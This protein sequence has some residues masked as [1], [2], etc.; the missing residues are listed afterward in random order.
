[1]KSTDLST[2]FGAMQP[3]IIIAS[4]HNAITLYNR[5]AGTR[6]VCSPAHRWRQCWHHCPQI[7]VARLLL[8]LTSY[9]EFRHKL[10]ERAT[11]KSLIQLLEPTLD[12]QLLCLL[13]QTVAIL[14][15]DPSLHTLFGEIQV[16][17][18]L[19]QMLLPADD[20]YYTNHSTKFG[21]FV[22]HHAARI[23]VYLGM[24]DR[25]GSRVNL[26]HAIDALNVEKR[27][28][29][30][31]NASKDCP[32]NNE[33]DFIIDTCKTVYSA[34]E[35]SKTALSVEGVLQK[36]LAEL[37]KQAPYPHT[38]EPITEESP[39]TSSPPALAVEP[40]PSPVVPAIVEEA[41]IDEP[42]NRKKAKND[43]ANVLKVP[44]NASTRSDKP[45]RPKM[46]DHDH[47]PL[48]SESSA[49]AVAQIPTPQI[50]TITTTN[51]SSSAH[52]SPSASLSQQ[53]AAT[54]MVPA[55]LTSLPYGQQI[56]AS[57]LSSMICVANL[58]TYLCKTSL[59]L[60]SML[61]LR[62][63]LHK[64]RWDLGLVSKR[65]AIAAE[66]HRAE[67]K[68]MTERS[69]V[70]SKSFDRREE[71]SVKSS[72]KRFLRVDQGSRLSRRVHIRRSSSVEILRP[73]RFSSGA[74]ELKMKERR[75]R[76][77]TDTSSGSGRSKKT[78]SSSSSV[79]KHLPR[80]IQSLFR[81]R[82]GT[83]PCKRH[84]PRGDS[85]PDSNTSSSEAV[86]EF[87][88]KL[89][90]FPQT[91]RETMRQAYRN[92]KQDSS[93]SNGE[94]RARALGYSYLPEVEVNGASPPR[95]PLE[96]RDSGAS[97]LSGARRPSSPQ[98]IP[99]LPLIEIRRP[100]AL[101]QFEFGYFVNSPEMC[102]NNTDVS[103]CA[104]LLLS[105]NNAPNGSRK[106]SD[107]SSVCGWSSRASSAMS[108]RSSS[109]GLRLSTFSAGTSIA[110]DNSGPF[111]FS[112]VLRKRA[113]T[114]GTRIPLPKRAISRSSGDSLR[115]PDRESPLHLLTI[116]E[117]SPDFQCVRQLL[118]NLMM[119]YS[120]N[121]PTFVQTMN[122]CAE[123]FR[124][125]LNS[126]QHPT[127]KN[128]CSEIMNVVNAQVDQEDEVKFESDERVNDEYLDLQDQIISGSLPCPREEAALLASIQLCVEENWPSNKRTQ[129]IRRH[130]LK[131]QF[132]RIRDLAQ[133]IMVTPW[134]V[135]QNL[136]CTPPRVFSE[137]VARKPSLGI[138]E[139][140]RRSIALLRCIS[141]QDA[142]MSSEL[143]ALCLP[144]D[145][146]GDRRTIKLI[147]ER[148]R[149]LFHSR[150]YESE[151]GMKKLYTQTAK[152]LPAHG[153]KV[154]QVKELLHGRTLR[155]TVRL[156]CLSS[157]MIC[158]LDGGSKLV[159]KRAHASTLQQWRV[160]GGISKHQLLLEFRGQKWQC[161]APSCSI[162][163]SISMTLWEIMQSTA[164]S[165]IQRSFNCSID[166]RLSIGARTTDS[167]RTASYSSN[168]SFPGGVIGDE[169]ITLFRLE[170][171]RLQYIL[172]FTEEVA[173]QLSLT[174]YQLFYG[175]QP[176]DFVR[177]VGCDLANIP[178]VDNPS[179]VK[180][181][182]KRLSEVSSWI[183]HVIISQP[184]H[185][186]RK[187][188]L[189]SIIRIID[190]C[191]HIGNFNGAIEILM[192]LRSD[193]LR[194]F[195]LS[196]KHEER[197]RYEE[198]IDVLL[199]T[200]NAA[201][202]LGYLEAVQRAL[203]MPQCRLIPFFG[204]FLR[205]LY[206]IV[207]E[208]PN[209]VVIGNEGEAE[210]LKFLNDVNGDDHFSS[211]LGVAGLLNTDK[212]NMISVVLE[213]LEIFHKHSRAL[214]KHIEHINN[215]D[216]VPEDSPSDAKPYDPVQPIPNSSHG[217]TLIPLDSR[218]FDLDVIQRIQHGTTV[219]HY[220]PDSG[221]SVLCRLML[222]ASCSTLSWHKIYYG[223]TKDGKDKE[224]LTGII[225]SVNMQNLQLPEGL[226]VAQSPY[227]TLRPLGAAMTGLEEGFLRTSFI[228]AIES[229]DTYDI[230]IETIYRRHSVEEM[231]VPVLAWTIN[232]GCMLS[233]NEILY[234]MAPQ[235]V[236]QCWIN[237]LQAVVKMIHE[238]QKNAD[239]R[240][241]W[242][243]KL[244]LQLYNEC[245]RGDSYIA[246]YK[247]I[248]PKP[249]DALQAFGGRVDR[250]RGLTIG[251][252][253]AIST[254]SKPT[255]SSSSNEGGGAKSRLK[256]MTIQI[257][258]RV[259][260]ASR[261]ASRSQSP[262]PQSPLVRPPSIKSQLSSQSGPPGPNSPGYLLKP[263]GDTAMSDAGDL[264]SLYTPRSRTPTSSS[265]GGRSVGGRSIKS[266]RSRG[267]ETPNSG[268]M[269]SSG[270]VSGLN[271]LSGREYQEKPLNFVEF[272]E[273]FRLFSTRMRKD[274]KDLFND[275][276]IYTTANA[277]NKTGRDKQS[278]RLQSRMESLSYAPGSDFIPNDVLTRNTASH[279]FHLNDK[280]LKIYNALALT[281]VFSNNFMDTSRNAFFLT[282]ASLKQFV[283][284]QQMEQIDE[285]YALKLIQEHEPDPLFRNKQLMSF[286][287]FVR[288][289]S[290]PVNFAFVP[291]A[292][293]PRAED[294]QMPLGYY[295]ICSSHNTYLT[296]HQLKG[297][298]STEMYRQVLLTGC[299]CVELDCFDGDEGMPLIYHGHT[300]TTKIAFRP[301]VDIIKKSAFQTSNLPVI[302]SLENHCSLQQ[303]AKMAQMFK[304]V[305]GDKLVTNFLF[306]TDYGDSPKL[307]SPWQL[308]NKI[309]IK[310]KKLIAEP[311]AGLSFPD[312]MR[313][314][315]VNTL[316]RKASRG[317]Y[318]SS[319]I[320]DVEE[321]ELDDFLDDDEPDTED[322]AES[323][324][325][326]RRE[327]KDTI[328]TFT[329]VERK[330]SNQKRVRKPIESTVSDFKA[331]DDT[332]STTWQTAHH[333][334]RQPLGGKHPTGHQIAQELSDLVIYSQAVKFKGFVMTY[335]KANET[336]DLNPTPRLRCNTPHLSASSA[337]RRMKSSS[338]I[339]TTDSI[340]STND[341]LAS[342]MHAS[343]RSNP[344]TSASCFQV[345]SITEASA[346]KLCRKHPFKCIQYTRDHVMRTY[347]GG[348][349]IDSSNF[350]P[351]QFWQFG[352]QMVALNYQTADT[353]MAVNAAMFEQSGNCGYALKPRPLWD[354][355]HPLF[356]KFNPL[357]KDN[358][359][360]DAL[361]LQLTVLS[362]QYVC[363]GHFGGS[364][365]LEIEIIGIPA[366]CCKEKT[367]IVSRNS[368][369]PMWN[370]SCTFR[371]TFVDL[372]FLRIAVCDSASNG[373]IVSQRV[374]P[375][376]CLRPGYRHLPLRTPANQALEQ[377][378]LFLRTRFELE[379]HIYLHEG[380]APATP[381]YE[382]ELAY[383]ILKV[384]PE[385][386]IRPLNILRRQIFVI[387][388][389]GLYNDDTPVLVHA[390][391]SSTVKHVIQIAL[392]NAGKLSE[393][394]D[395]YVLSK[396]SL[397]DPAEV[398]SIGM[399]K[400]GDVAFMED[401]PPN[402]PILDIAFW[403]NKTRRFLLRK[404]A[405][406]PSARTRSYNFTFIKN[407]G[408][409]NP[410]PASSSTSTSTSKKVGEWVEAIRSSGA[411]SPS[412]FVAISHHGTRSFD[413]EAIESR[414]SMDYLEPGGLPQRAKS[415]GETFLICIHNV[416]DNH[417]Y[418][419]LRTGVNNTARDII[420]QIMIKTQRYDTDE[421]EFV[422]VEEV[423]DQ[424]TEFVRPTGGKWP[425]TSG[426]KSA[427]RVL[428]H[429]ENVWKAQ[430]R[431][432]KA[433]G[434]FLLERKDE[435]EGTTKH[436][437]TETCRK[438]S[439]SNVRS[440]NI[441][442]RISRFGKSL[443]LDGG[444]NHPQ[445]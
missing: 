198:L 87:T 440:I 377:S 217:V 398:V 360:T 423:R 417:P 62:L 34:H 407:S 164:S 403:N 130:L 238:Q 248:G 73:K 92:S 222:D 296:G 202:S 46:R 246:D 388:V 104:P 212:T 165:V 71:S 94:T 218:R 119:M 428:D 387:R 161:I 135:D 366:D 436:L 404:K 300:L 200:C 219:I 213:N 352:L 311:S 194:P 220:D 421:T 187:N 324:K 412:G 132:G 369:N 69:F 419:I 175:I 8:F 380:D 342:A 335:D 113:S 271:G 29:A 15:M 318:D 27:P 343:G 389:Q 424:P 31:G 54:V 257:T 3:S 425:D 109:G 292:I 47:R 237:G 348:M 361:I 339:S 101:S 418:A 319:T 28:P 347:P 226:K 252:N 120:R 429:D 33:D 157:S 216:A 240:V 323:S 152:K 270:A 156:L 286:E 166:H 180:N 30:A 61:L 325:K 441:P 214:Q 208:M 302:L 124:Q 386:Q 50:P 255:D 79:H 228:K 344:N 221:R 295:Y 153:C 234:F 103:D 359:N 354:Q 303:Q 280:Q 59:V 433:A 75:K 145:L 38:S 334:Q 241:L 82:M 313:C 265:Y 333:G 105:G 395:D 191:W 259:K 88:R 11:L 266:W 282:P 432:G 308:R 346:R 408:I 229:V 37:A 399:R 416:S 249:I 443:T 151:I 371:I 63:L 268:S 13:L 184:T 57:T 430:T 141:D 383:Q 411:T 297:E 89:Q 96:G 78:N 181:L 129:T 329:S 288:Y 283:C 274:I 65:R 193:K 53:P 376:K 80:Y 154:F 355:T 338:A 327:S 378:M 420:K 254:S 72:D 356:G 272:V 445:N 170:L 190:T 332:L 167:S 77:G 90:N 245:E 114:I 444:R 74:K 391:S 98:A 117:M 142:T 134:E 91:R 97:L 146:R 174:E 269:S 264:D 150:V 179:T 4:L 396:E 345:T 122:A 244:Y 331:D 127:V 358:A 337:P 316:P 258:R 81:G 287:G 126:P 250:L 39:G 16:D 1:M 171:E 317:S 394:G 64:L 281:S 293:T 385:A 409:T 256:Q 304:T 322:D 263:R 144:V 149:K 70:K 309:L 211:N 314:G 177:Y 362:G 86:L 301:V 93:T 85:S 405:S 159:L 6:S 379:E 262:Q 290:D 83:D 427:Y 188:C 76:L 43:K 397:V 370:H 414:H 236:A 147:R 351:V 326:D 48:A 32:H 368:V 136:Y 336:G 312:R 107:E 183:T 251:A 176:L 95:S 426:K 278:P 106:S 340:K 349:R 298:S 23:L 41:K 330:N 294:M 410:P 100:S 284:T 40:I 210:K 233:D 44:S 52:S 21:L 26:F 321:D 261:D 7:L 227:A 350:N 305:F 275:C 12:P 178:I 276:I 299:R 36:I 195:W 185:E 58:E 235:Q 381:A 186:E 102:G 341:D 400:E 215:P 291:E 5:E 406:D 143:Q 365:Y 374:V 112:F 168:C 382:P 45:D 196:L 207:N 431:W 364:P 197:Q 128:W 307:P 139:Q 357:S 111:L 442:R 173:F 160:G 55:A 277:H 225:T 223:G 137:S 310:N 204:T 375:V 10:C 20:F 401:L 206:A 67:K 438:I 66:N 203:R 437:K 182:V 121:H 402:D 192:G 158:L 230:D 353:S 367:K 279:Q 110:S 118:L 172:H 56:S 19:I 68:D 199:P 18:V 116:T 243:K 131:G 267:G 439:L 22:K 372:A 99:G 140:R 115:V 253:Q 148:K 35:F 224:N 413:T 108:Q 392:A 24:G 162:L 260:G 320:D 42:K 273:L 247:K 25:V 133:K 306:D 315:D 60:D 435:V 2:V 163:K 422:L 384:D 189:S 138:Q 393:N 14:A 17:D 390:E 242:I 51:A 285:A 123:L 239:R 155:K 49:P 9:K 125:V 232:F 231:S 169:P 434:R 84:T 328:N 201:P 415:M 289:L 209:I 205:D 373:R 363:P